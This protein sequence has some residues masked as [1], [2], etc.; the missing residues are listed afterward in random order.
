MLESVP[1]SLFNQIASFLSAGEVVFVAPAGK[2]YM[3]KLVDSLWATLGT[4][5]YPVEFAVRG[6]KEK[7]E[8]ERETQREKRVR[9]R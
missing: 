1:A 4:R 8:R 3:K 5:D 6:E 7:G 2:P 9:E